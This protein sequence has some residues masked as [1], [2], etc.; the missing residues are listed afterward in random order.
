MKKILF[1]LILF[2]IPICYATTTV[3]INT[4]ITLDYVGNDQLYI[5]TE[6][7][8]FLINASDQ[9]DKSFNIELLREMGDNRTDYE[10]LYD[11]ISSVNQTCSFLL[12]DY[13]FSE[14]YAHSLSEIDNCSKQLYDCSE[15]KDIYKD[16]LEL[17]QA[18]QNTYD[19]N[20]SICRNDLQLCA[21]DRALFN[22]YNMD[23]QTMLS[24]ITQEYNNFKSTSG[25]GFNNGVFLGFVVTGIIAI[26]II[27]RYA[28]KNRPKAQ[29][30]YGY[31]DQM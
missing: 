5:R 16:H 7:E 8:D 12:D 3:R 21:N 24:N 14:K 28:Q 11:H 18:A 6:T 22:T 31:A 2:L 10:R 29:R 19:A 27:S 15:Q 9:T 1:V 17:A 30:E 26:I 4:T 23:C 25:S 20:I 13:N